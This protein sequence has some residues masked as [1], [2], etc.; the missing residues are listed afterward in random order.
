MYHVMQCINKKC[1]AYHR[2]VILLESPREQRERTGQYPSC[3]G[4]D[5]TLNFVAETA[6]YSTVLEMELLDEA[7]TEG[8]VETHP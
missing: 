6:S 8:P 7:R 1:Q 4:C 5:H 2:N 3:F